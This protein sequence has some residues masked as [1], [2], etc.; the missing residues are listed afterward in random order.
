M[1]KPGS[2]IQRIPKKKKKENPMVQ[3]HGTE[4]QEHY[5]TL[6]LSLLNVRDERSRAPTSEGAGKNEGAGRKK[7]TLLS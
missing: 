6:V 3:P 7:S 1:E 5:S 2:E 4:A